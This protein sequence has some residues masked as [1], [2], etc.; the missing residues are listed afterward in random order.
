MNA[1]RYDSSIIPHTVRR[2]PRHGRIDTLTFFLVLFLLLPVATNMYCQRP[3]NADS[4]AD[5]VD[6]G[7]GVP[8]E[9]SSGLIGL[10]AGITSVL[11]IELGGTIEGYLA[12][13]F[14]GPD[15]PGTYD[16]R[17]AVSVSITLECHPWSGMNAREK[18]K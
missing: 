6:R 2:S 12:D 5:V 18:E 16:E 1:I 7:R 11:R 14:S 13:Y 8:M 17:S 9:T 15:R 4:S 10:G 3:V